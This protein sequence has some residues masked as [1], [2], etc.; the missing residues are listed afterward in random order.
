MT[1]SPADD[2]DTAAAVLDFARGESAAA[3][4]PRANSSTAAAVSRSP[5]LLV[6]T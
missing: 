4:S 3:L 6:M 2:L 5:G 1:G